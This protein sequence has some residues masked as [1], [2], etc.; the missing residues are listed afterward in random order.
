MNESQVLHSFACRCPAG[1]IPPQARTLRELRDPGVRFFCELCDAF[2][3]P[4]DVDRRRALAFAEASDAAMDVAAGTA[5][6]AAAS[7]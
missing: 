3:T 2:W 5:P 1:H 4:P 7:A 6:G